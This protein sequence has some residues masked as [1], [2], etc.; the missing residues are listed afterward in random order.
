[1]ETTI[2]QK[3]QNE[4]K[5]YSVTDAALAELQKQWGEFVIPADDASLIES[6]REA[7]KNVG[8]LRRDV[9]AERKDLKEE[10]LTIGK[11]IDA[12]AKQIQA[13]IATVEGNL[14]TQL[15]AIDAEEKKEKAMKVARKVWPARAEQLKELGVTVA[16]D[17]LEKT[18]L[19]TEAQFQYYCGQIRQAKLDEQQAEIDRL[20]REAREREDAE[21]RAKD[22]E[23]AKVQAAADERARI[24]REQAQAEERKKAEAERAEAQRKADEEAAAKA[25]AD[26]LAAMSDRQRFKVWAQS[27]L[28][29]ERPELKSPKA[30]DALAAIVG[31]LEKV[32]K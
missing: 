24:E 10:S 9:E 23:A 19:L 31:M 27:C 29:I 21:Q 25:E 14:K 6:A 28:D 20:K 5:R 16:D 7:L 3:I 26:R 18:M 13:V 11:G 1:M 17:D 32:A 8:Q 30:V 4:V 12:K 2:E 15:D 22:I